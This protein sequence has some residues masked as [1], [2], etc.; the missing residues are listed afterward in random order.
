MV[1][2]AEEAGGLL[3]LLVWLI[4]GAAMVVP[5]LEHAT[6]PDYLFALLALTVGA[7]GPGRRRPPGSGLDRAPWASSGGSAPVGWPRWCSAS[8]PTTASIAVDAGQVLSIVTVTVAL[9]VLAHGL[10]ASPLAARYGAFSATLAGHEPEH[11]AMPSMR[12]RRSLG[13]HIGGTRK[14]DA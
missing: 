3:S 12:P 13:G 5:G 8:S 10:S 11:R 4:F 2:F 14:N 6:W 7:D 1:G 9:S